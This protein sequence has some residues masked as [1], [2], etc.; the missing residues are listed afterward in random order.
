MRAA[1]TAHPQPHTLGKGERDFSFREIETMKTPSL[2]IFPTLAVLLGLAVL[3]GCDRLPKP[4][5]RWSPAPD[6]ATAR[7]FHSATL[8]SDGRVLIVGGLGTSAYL[9]SAEIYD[10]ATSIWSATGSM[11]VVR[12]YH[13]AT[14]LQN[15]KV[16]VVGGLS[17][18]AV[19]VSAS[20]WRA[21]AELYDPAT[22]TWSS[23]STMATGRAYHTASLLV[24]GDVVIVGGVT[25]PGLLSSTEI[26]TPSTAS[27]SW[28]TA[29]SMAAPRAR[30][31]AVTLVDGLTVLVAGG[32]T[33]AGANQ[34]A[35]PTATAEQYRVAGNAW[36]TAGSLHTARSDLSLTLLSVAAKVLAAG[37]S[38]GSPTTFTADADLYSG[39]ASGT[40]GTW[41]TLPGIGSSHS[42]H[43]ATYL[44]AIQQV[45][46]AGG[47]PVVGGV[48]ASRFDVAS[49]SW[50][51][52]GGMRS[53]RL[54]HT[55]TLL[56]DGRVLVV[57]GYDNTVQN[58]S[59]PPHSSAEFFTP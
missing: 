17:L 4:V 15:G 18:P 25:G 55:A 9:A 58:T 59:Y 16:L 43:T 49:S 27:G 57:G 24:N 56:L 11:S 14:L 41:T 51:Y 28:R 1:W 52:D 3:P 8:L 26:Y 40:P 21:D 37:G 48:A 2:Q 13:T 19:P 42:G 12:A 33:S 36:S 30:H 46:V 29:A 38:R 20:G 44:P 7:K 50:N 35:T 22:G 6:M 47:L 53:R 23:A 45:L 5:I 39:G 54:G 34:P 31:G 10:P 32:I